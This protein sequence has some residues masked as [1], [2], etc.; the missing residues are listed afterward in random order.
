MSDRD[1]PERGSPPG[2]GEDR[3]D[4]VE[5]VRRKLEGLRAAET[6]QP[7]ASDGESKLIRL[8]HR[9]RRMKHD[10]GAPPRKPWQAPGTVFD[11]APTR[12]VMRSELQR[13]TGEW[14]V[15]AD[16]AEDGVG[17]QDASVVDLAALRRKRAAD[18]PAAGIRRVAK[19]RRVD[20]EQP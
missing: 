15:D 2:P 4:A 8:P 10:A 16:P 5:R 20:P 1:E 9:P 13:E 18:A 17:E 11:P 7:D 14:P 6:D 19:P 3:L 12:P